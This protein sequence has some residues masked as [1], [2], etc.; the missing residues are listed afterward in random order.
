MTKKFISRL[1]LVQISVNP[2]YA[3]EL[4]S[5]IQEPTFPE[6]NQKTGLFSISGLEEIGRLQQNLAEKYISHLNHKVESIVR[7]AAADGVELLVFPEYSIPPETLPLCKAL[8]EELGLAIIAGSHVVTISDAAQEIYKALELTFEDPRTAPEERVRQAACVVFR[9]GEKPT[10]FV[11]YVKSKWETA[12]VKGAPAFHTFQMKTKAGR[13]EVQVLICIEALSGKPQREKHN[14]ARLIAIT[15]FTP[16]VDPFHDEGARA[17]LQGKCTLFANVAEFG[18]SAAFARADNLSLWFTQ[19]NGSTPLPPR[20]EALIVVEADLER[21][22]EIRQLVTERTAVT[23]L[24][25]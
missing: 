7:F 16:R 14:I 13:I 3:D 9:P 10:A 22:F 25:V 21:Q 8:S 18:G 1:G 5:A 19:K 12:L 20:S 17:L 23:D 11:K 4:V 6:E 2:A 24:R 15:A